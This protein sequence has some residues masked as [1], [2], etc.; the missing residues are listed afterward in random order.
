ML[1]KD[2]DCV[3]KIGRDARDLQDLEHT[4]RFMTVSA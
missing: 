3:R 4:L 1:R 2:I